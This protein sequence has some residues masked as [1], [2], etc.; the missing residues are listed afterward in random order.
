MDWC[1]IQSRY[2][3]VWMDFVADDQ[4]LTKKIAGAQE[5]SVYRAL[6]YAYWGKDL[7][8]KLEKHS[9][10]EGP[11]KDKQDA[12]S[13]CQKNLWDPLFW[14]NKWEWIDN[15]P[16]AEIKDYVQTRMVKFKTANSPMKDRSVIAH[17]HSH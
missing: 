15:S 14:K 8:K 17:S 4:C 13:V 9:L 16:V 11:N 5:E 1:L 6:I 10:P 7:E 2:T 3:E 12:L